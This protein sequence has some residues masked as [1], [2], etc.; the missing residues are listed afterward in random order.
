M[1]WTRNDVGHVAVD[2]PQAILPL[3]AGE[4]EA[5]GVKMLALDRRWQG[6]GGSRAWG[7]EVGDYNGG[8]RSVNG[9]RRAR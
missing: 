5:P 9:R 8:G 7:E 2:V 4:L 1:S 3:V 6:H